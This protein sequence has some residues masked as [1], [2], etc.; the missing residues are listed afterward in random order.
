MVLRWIPDR[1]QRRTDGINKNETS[2][3]NKNSIETHRVLVLQGGGALGAY[4]AGVYDVLYY[5][6]K[7]DQDVTNPLKKYNI[8]DVIA[9]TSIGAINAAILVSY[10]KENQ[11]SWEGSTEKLLNFWEHVSS[12]P[13]LIDYWP[14]WPNW[15]FS[16]DEKSWMKEWNRLGKTESE[17]ATGEAARRY[18]SA[19]KFLL[20]G[21]PNF[22]SKPTKFNDDRFLDDFFPFAGNIWY[23]YSN[24][25]LIN[26]VKKFV[27]KFPIATGRDEPR[28]LLV[29]VDVKTGTTIT[30]DSYSKTG[31]VN[32]DHQS[33]V[34]KYE[35][36][37]DRRYDFSISYDEGIMPEHLLASASV[38][39]NFDYMHVPTEYDYSSLGKED[40]FSIA[41]KDN[42]DNLGEKLT[43]R[44]CW[45]GGLLS[46]SPLREVI[47]AHKLFWELQR[48]AKL[49]DIKTNSWNEFSKGNRFDIPNLQVYIVDLWP[50]K[51]EEIPNDHDKVLD[52]KNDITYQNKT[53]YDQKVAV[54]VS[55]YI[56]L[57]EKI[58]DIA[59]EAINS[60]TDDNKKNTLSS[61]FNYLLT[62][63]AKSKQRDGNVRQYQDLIKGR[64][65][66]ETTF[67]LE[68]K[69]DPDTISNKWFDLSKTT[70]TKLINDGRVQTLMK[71]YE[72]E[73]K[74]NNENHARQEM[75]KFID[76]VDRSRE[77]GEIESHHADY[78]IKL[79]KVARKE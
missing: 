14:H 34:Y 22:F 56:D 62:E 15:P 70:I 61:K 72:N 33:R 57:V 36:Y 52:R 49:E 27:T 47:S 64:F 26:S 59:V 44:C 17:I 8:F 19:K 16:W 45:D 68:R 55:D 42:N 10:V 58:G 69:D 53:D 67:H 32:G 20:H 50:S 71:L 31:E 78:L 54:F 4:E 13:D 21:A 73:E 76:T 43:T 77:K 2:N 41:C 38:P 5:W 65:D 48:E 24:K 40:Y 39:V 28:L 11:G 60:I 74:E 12:T 30:F 51:E 1:M 7:K 23:K 46:N 9:G 79:A 75:G 66:L 35:N 3:N 6:I 18:Y 63:S 29:S 37:E 25:P